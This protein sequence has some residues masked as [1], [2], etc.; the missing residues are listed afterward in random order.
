MTQLIELCKKLNCEY[1]E[2]EPMNKHTTF[3]IGGNARLVVYPSSLEQISAIVKETEKNNVRLI[4]IGNGSNLLVDD[5]GIDA[6]V[7]ILDDRFGKIHLIDD[8]TLF[9]QSGA[10]L[11]KLCR[12]AL[13]HELTG[14]EFAYGIPGTCGGGA[15]MNAGAYGG[16]MK[17]VLYK[18]QHIDQNGNIAE[19]EGDELKLSYRHSAYYDNGCIITGLYLKLKRGDKSEIKAKMDDLILRRRDKQPLEFASAGSTFKRPEG[20]FAGAL[21]QECGLKGKTVGGAQVSEKHAGFVI[22]RGG[23]TCSD[24]L[25]LCKYCSDTVLREKGV[26][27]E[28]EIRVTK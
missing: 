12:F 4:T 3:K 8:E 23:A 22:N 15:F 27:L 14:L 7:M 20:Y 9:V 1:A 24:V 28:M 11:I 13:E 17:D 18:C 19:L 25:E 26:K 5:N 16:E 21:I 2:Y 6:C 10:M